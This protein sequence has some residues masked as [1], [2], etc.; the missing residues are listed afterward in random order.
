MRLGPWLL[1]TST[2]MAAYAFDEGSGNVTSATP[3]N[4]AI[5]N[6]ASWTTG[7]FGNA[8]SFNG[9]S[10]YVEATGTNSVTP[11]TAATF[12]AWVYLSATPAELVSVLNKWSQSAD[13][14]YLFGIN[15]GGTLLF[16]W[17]TT[18]GGVYGST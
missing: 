7:R 15:P 11:G 9:S 12:E 5:L 16:S 10:S 14:E 8:V 13:D 1:S 2:L 17:Q 18:G 3:G 4:T 6:N